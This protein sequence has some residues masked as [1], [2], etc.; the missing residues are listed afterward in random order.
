MDNV[1]AELILAESI[2]D[3]KHPCAAFGWGN[4]KSLTEKGEDSLWQDLKTFF[5]TQ[6]S[7]ERMYIVVQTMVPNGKDLSEVKQ[8]VK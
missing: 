4:K 3:K 5:D 1:R 7:A 8:W 2:T 6:Y